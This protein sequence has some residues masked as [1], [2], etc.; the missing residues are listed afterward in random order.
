MRVSEQVFRGGSHSDTRVDLLVGIGTFTGSTGVRPM[1]RCFS[2]GARKPRDN[3]GETQGKIPQSPN[4]T[5]LRENRDPQGEIQGENQGKPGNPGETQQKPKGARTPKQN[6]D[7]IQ[8]R[9]KKENKETVT[10]QKQT[11]RKP[12]FEGSKPEHAYPPARLPA[13]PSA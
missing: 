11:Q 8:G 3:S 4:R 10:N 12:Q 13:P 5:H 9:P 6:P 2:H 1:A 7:K